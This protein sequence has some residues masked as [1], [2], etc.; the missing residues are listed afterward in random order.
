MCGFKPQTSLSSKT[1]A[2][3]FIPRSA[4]RVVICFSMVLARLTNSET[5]FN[6]AMCGQ[7]LKSA[8]G[9]RAKAYAS[10]RNRSPRVVDILWLNWEGERVNYTKNGL[11]QGYKM[12]MNTY[13]GHPWIFR[14]HCSGDKLVFVA[15]TDGQSKEVFFPTPAGEERPHATQVNIQLPVYTLLERSLQVLRNLIRD[16]SDF[17]KLEIPAELK[18]QLA[19]PVDTVIW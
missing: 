10:F 14:D 18:S 2:S 19:N 9:H 11:K 12:D 17:D 8:P 4:K 15:G 1:S 16:K 3:V 7:Q 5:P 13:E 6:F